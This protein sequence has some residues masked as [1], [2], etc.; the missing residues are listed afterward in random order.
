MRLLTRTTIYFLTVMLTL[1]GVG[2]FFL[3]HSFSKAL[4][5]KT[6]EELIGEEIQWIR[7]L[8]AQAD[9]GTTFILKTNEISIYPV[10]LPVMQFPELRNV[11][12]GNAGDG[13]RQFYRELNQV[14][15]VNGM[16]YKI[17]LKKSQEQKAALITN[18]TRILILVFVLLLL[19]A[20]IFNWIISRK[21]W[22]PFR[23]TLEK[24]RNARLDKIQSTR[25]EMTNTVEFNELNVALNEMTNKIHQDFITMKE[26][27][28]NA[29]HEM[30]TPIAVIQSK[31]ELLLQDTNLSKEQADSV[32]AALDSLERLGKL[33]ESFLLLAKIE[34]NQYRATNRVDLTAIV[35]KYLSLFSELINDKKLV[36]VRDFTAPFS[37]LLH[38]LLADSLVVNLLGNAIKYNYA[39][40][41]IKIT[42]SSD[43]IEI[44]N[45]SEL[46]PIKKE[47]LF[48]R[49]AGLQ[50]D[51]TNSTGLGLAIAKKIA[52]ANQLEL[53]YAARDGMHVFLLSEKK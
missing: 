53:N 39:G 47:R 19:S 22:A 43:H 5:K 28:E 21:L 34:N 29:A 38:P 6:D 40:G 18:F 20:L 52:D 7:Y 51:G 33:N 37:V 44:S 8:Q 9:N 50:G 2:A 1:T 4:D 49:F 14:V 46:A 27:T 26:F 17:T 36:V 15:P 32:V 24:I 3:Y 16:A 23:R 45:T 35:Q 11:Q 25:Y 31:L 10:S 12:A 13:S 41:K 30:Q 48:K 42:S